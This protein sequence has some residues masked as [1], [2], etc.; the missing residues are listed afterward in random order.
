MIGF[1]TLMVLT[2]S[3]SGGRESILCSLVRYGGA[4]HRVRSLPFFRRNDF[5]DTRLHAVAIDFGNETL[6]AAELIHG[7]FKY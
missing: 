2:R 5:D 4:Q 1:L 6:E 3:S 7:L